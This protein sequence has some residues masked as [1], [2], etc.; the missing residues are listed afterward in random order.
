MTIQSIARTVILL[1][2]LVVG[3]AATSCDSS[4][5]IGMSPAAGPR[6]GGGGMTGPPIFPGGPSR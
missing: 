4:S 5:G 6:W 2:L 3:L 1:T